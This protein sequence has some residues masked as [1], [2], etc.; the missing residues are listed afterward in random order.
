MIQ[1]LKFLGMDGRFGAASAV[2]WVLYRTVVG[3]RELSQKV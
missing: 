2:T 1:S 3:K